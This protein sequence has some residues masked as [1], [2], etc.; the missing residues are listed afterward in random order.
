MF[1]HPTVNVFR[2]HSLLSLSLVSQGV[3][4]MEEELRKNL[5]EYNEV[6]GNYT[7][8]ERKET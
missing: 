6:R 4:K 7:A 1:R 3:L 8:I 2:S 5:S